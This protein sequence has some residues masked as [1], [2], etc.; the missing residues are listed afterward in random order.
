MMRVAMMIAAVAIA[1]LPNAASAQDDVQDVNV[2]SREAIKAIGEEMR[3][4]RLEGHRESFRRQL[5]EHGMSEETV[6]SF[7]EQ[8]QR[9]FG[10]RPIVIKRQ[11]HG[12]PD[13]DLGDRESTLGLVERIQN[14]RRWSLERR[15]ESRMERFDNIGIPLKRPCR[16]CIDVVTDCVEAVDAIYYACIACECHSL[17]YC[18]DIWLTQFEICEDLFE[19]QCEE[20]SC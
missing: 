14:L 1:V 16:G 7:V 3:A 13:F 17:A 15:M 6:D 20:D 12:Y 11:P 9:F 4:I 8:V 10:D 2:P 18:Q 5:L 19:E